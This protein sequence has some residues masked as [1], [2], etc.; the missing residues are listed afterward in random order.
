MKKL[1]L[2]ALLVTPSVFANEAQDVKNSIKNANENL[3]TIKQM[4]CDGHKDERKASCRELLTLGFSQ[5]EATGRIKELF[6]IK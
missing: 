2:I 4:V 6:G 1:L 3:E 5:A